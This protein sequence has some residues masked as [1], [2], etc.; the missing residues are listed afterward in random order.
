MDRTASVRREVVHVRISE[1]LRN[2]YNMSRNDEIK[3]FL[4]G[5]MLGVFGGMLGPILDRYFSK[6]GLP[7][8]ILVAG[9]FFGTML[10]M[11]RYF[12]KKYPDLKL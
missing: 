9:I 6:F 1:V 3:T 12:N 10:L 11:M 8:E 2:G 4:T 7:Y 5:I